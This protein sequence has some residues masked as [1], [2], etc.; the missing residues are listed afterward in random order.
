VGIGGTF[1]YT[2][3]DDP[4]TNQSFEQINLRLNYEMTAKLALWASAGVE[5]RQFD[6]NRDTYDSPVF[7]LGLTYHPFSGTFLTLAAGRRIYPSGYVS[8]Q[9][10]G[11]TY[12]AGRFQQRLFH[13]VYFGL[14][15]GYENSDYISTNRNVSATRNDDYW[16]IEPSVDVLITRWLSAGVYYLHRED[17]SNQDFFDWKDNQVGVRATV[18]F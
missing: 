15:A 1:G 5:F 4:S 13:R 9:D 8:N 12:V 16:F 18:R 11:A 6:G 14:G 7:E 17:S 3:V 10:F 2:W